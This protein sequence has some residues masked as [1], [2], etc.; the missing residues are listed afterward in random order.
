MTIDERWSVTYPLAADETGM[1]REQR[2]AADDETEAHIMARAK[3]TR[4]GHA[5]ITNRQGLVATYVN[6]AEWRQ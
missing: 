1:Q 4:H 2:L 3:S 6:G 5:Y